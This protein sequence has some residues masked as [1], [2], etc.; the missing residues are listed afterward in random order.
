LLKA[1]KCLVYLENLSICMTL[2]LNIIIY[3]IFKK[4]IA[5]LKWI[6]IENYLIIMFIFLKKCV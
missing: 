6:L 3:S 1:L 5:W 4:A 2:N